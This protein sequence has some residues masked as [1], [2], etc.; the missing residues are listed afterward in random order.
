[1]D[2]INNKNTIL[3]PP[4]YIAGPTASGK[5]ALAVR[6]A[7]VFDSVIISADSMQIYRG[8]DIGTAKE[9]VEIRNKIPHKLID[10]VNANEEFSV[11]EFAQMAK[12]EISNAQNCGKL[13][14]IVGGTGLYF[15]SLL[16]PMSFANTIKNPELREELQAELQKNG[17]LAMHNKLESLDKE[18]ADRLHVNDTKRVVR[19]LEIILSTGKTLAQNSDERQEP[20]VIM[21]ALDTDRAVLYERINERVDKMFNDGLVNEV[22]SV[23]NFDYQSMQAIGY[24]EFA[25]CHY[26]KLNGEYV[27]NDEELAQ[28]KNKIKQHTRNYAK[29]Q[30][31]WFRKYPFVKWFDVNDQ[32]GAIAYLTQEIEA[33]SKRQSS[34][35]QKI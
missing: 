31:T 15:E 2:N 7:S 3:Y 9:S 22:L 16:Y 21:I 14:I 13:P 28:I 23:G 27:V 11:A 17:A 12:A 20:D 25:A 24:K 8:L 5:S 4:V 18:T 29:R 30:L 35:C 32:D 33:K 26:Q 19:A 1:M 6:L 10:V 34:E